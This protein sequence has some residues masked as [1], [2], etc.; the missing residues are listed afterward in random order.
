MRIFN[1]N[2]LIQS[3]S[4]STCCERHVFFIRK[5]ICTCSFV[6]YVFHTVYPVEKVLD[7]EF[8]LLDC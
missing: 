7:T 1:I 5:I 8:N 6:C 2:V 4:A 3:L